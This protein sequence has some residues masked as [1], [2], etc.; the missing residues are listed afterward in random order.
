MI[1][2]IL[3]FSDFNACR[4]SGDRTAGNVYQKQN[5]QMK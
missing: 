5:Y 2:V 1:L 3:F 4:T